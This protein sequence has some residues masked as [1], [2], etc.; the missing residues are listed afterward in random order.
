MILIIWIAS[1]IVNALLSKRYHRSQAVW[2]LWAIPFGFLSTIV[3]LA[4]GNRSGQVAPSPV[5]PSGSTRHCTN[6]GAANGVGS[7][8]CWHCGA[9]LS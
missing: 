9:P 5:V 8:Y 1:I 2:I 3:L 6:C 7:K 4:A